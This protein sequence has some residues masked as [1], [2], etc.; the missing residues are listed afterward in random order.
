MIVPEIDTPKFNL[1]LIIGYLGCIYFLPLQI[2]STNIYWAPMCYY[3]MPDIILGTGA[4]A[5]T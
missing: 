5:P 4:T 2:H 1:A 3:S